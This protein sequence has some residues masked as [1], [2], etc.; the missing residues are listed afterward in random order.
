MFK[1]FGYNKIPLHDTRLYCV[2]DLETDIM[3]VD[4]VSNITICPNQPLLLRC[5]I[6]G[7]FLPFPEWENDGITLDASS[8]ACTSKVKE[9]Q[10]I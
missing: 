5:R 2:S 1:T 10:Y 4:E 9:V 7:D 3:K 8:L 6:Q